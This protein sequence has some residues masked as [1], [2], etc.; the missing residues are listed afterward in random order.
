MWENVLFSGNIGL[1]NW[2]ENHLWLIRKT[3]IC[4]CTLWALAIDN[5]AVMFFATVLFVPAKDS[6]VIIFEIVFVLYRFDKGQ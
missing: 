6:Y 1:P 3:Q 4:K 5:Q 2:F